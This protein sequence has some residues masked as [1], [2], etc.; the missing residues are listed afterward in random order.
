M[1]INYVDVEEKKVRRKSRKF[2]W[3]KVSAGVIIFLVLLGSALTLYFYPKTRALVRDVNKVSAS[4]DILQEAIE[5]Q[6]VSA[7]KKA[8]TGLK[9]DLEKTEG[10][11]NKLKIVGLVPFINGYYNDSKHVVRAGVLASEAGEIVAESV[12]PFGDI[13]GLEGTKSNLKAEK[14]VEV[15]VTKVF[16]TLSARTEELEDYV[17]NIK[18]ELGQVNASRYPEALTIKDIKIRKTL[19]D[20]QDAIDKVE[21][22][23]PLLKTASEA[24]PSIMG[25]KKEKTYLM[26]FQNDKELRPTGGFIT[27]YGVAK[28][29]NGKLLDVTSD[30]IYSLD[31]QFTPF[32]TPPEVLQKYLVLSIYPIRDTNLSPDFRLSAQKFESFYN[33]IPDQPKVDGIIALDT[34]FVRKFL[35]VTGPIT[36]EKY[37]ETFSAENDPT[38][39]I[40]DVVYKLELYAERILRGTRHRKGLIGDLMDGMLEKLF[41]APPEK[42]PKIFNTF[43]NTAESKN[44]QFYFKDQKAQTLVEE[45]NYAG[46]IKDFNGD[47]L[48]VNNANFAGLK[49]N[50]YIR[51]AVEQDIVITED[52]QV[53]KKVK[54]TLRNIEKADGWLNSVYRNWMRL[55]VPKGS[56]LIDRKVFA[57]F[58]ENEDLGKTVW[59]SFS[60]TMPL[61]FSETSFTYKLPFKVKKGETYK[62][63]IQKQGGST[64][65]HMI[66]RV[67]GE[68]LFE[69]DLKKDTELEF[70]V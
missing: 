43:V 26:L 45:V 53:S 34:E 62:M 18:D 30:D 38:Y 19:L 8:V 63:L 55:Y 13:L 20:A 39:K 57:D 5:K 40:P 23:I 56:K 1:P 42:F 66:I 31:K 51:A 54:V 33:K 35:K 10:D 52:G 37:N 24:L 64:D 27:A 50:L 68:K 28:V 47:Y 46:R 12:L 65:P 48:H 59:K 21:E 32:E 9:S 44:I 29:K 25:Y 15:L 61:N 60:Q 36:V 7:A 16:P 49:G 41:S 58:A 3:L 22:A 70:K 4:A 11:L 17:E 6:N 14:K 2:F 69:F 67:N